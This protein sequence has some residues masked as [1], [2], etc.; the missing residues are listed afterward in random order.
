MGWVQLGM[1]GG[2]VGLAI[3]IIVHLMSGRRAR[4]IDLGTLRFLKVVLRENVRRKR[5]KRWLLLALRLTAVALLAFLFARP[6]LLARQTGGE[7]RLVI[8]LV[9][10]SASMGLGSGGQRPLDAAVRQATTVLARCGE[11]TQVEAAWFDHAIH[12]WAGLDS[13]KTSASPPGA[14]GS[15]LTEWASSRTPYGATDLGAAMAWA[16]DVAKQS[17]RSRKELYVYTDLQRSGLDRTAA[18]PLP[19]DLQV[20][21]VDL[22]RSY[23]ENVAVTAIELPKTVVRPGESMAI[24]VTLRNTGPFVRDEVPVT[25][26]LQNG[27]KSQEFHSQVRIEAGETIAVGFD[28][29]ALPEGLWQGTASIQLK[30]SLP[31]D[32]R[33]HLA[34]LVAPPI[35]VILVDGDAG[36]TGV[37]AETY[38]LEAAIGLAG[39]TKTFAA[40]LFTATRAALSGGAGLP[41]LRGVS[42]VVLANLP[43]LDAAAAQRL[44]DFVKRGAGLLVFS[45]ENVQADGYRSL[46]AAGIGVGQI[47]GIARAE[48]LPWR[49]EE[50][51]RAHPALEF[52]NDPQYGDLRRP[53]FQAYTRIQPDADAKVVAWFRGGEPAVL[54]KKLGAGRI[55]WVTT[56]CDFDW[57]D[58]PRSRLYVPMVHQMLGYLAHL[59]EGGPVRNVPLEKA[60]QGPRAVPG[61]FQCEGFHEVVNVDPRESESERCTAEQFAARFRFQVTPEEDGQTATRVAR[62]TNP[63]QLRQD[64]IWQWLVLGLFGCLLAEGF[65]GNRTTA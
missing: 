31:F 9:D 34:F 53:A 19:D 1:L 65:L 23:P 16:G 60:A 15:R 55:L 33:R 61:V 59:A 47:G 7:D 58:W 57:G 40:S 17:R 48:S 25:L 28:L 36:R 56:A 49:F 62:A 21:L 5:L 30:D 45:G 64:E 13:A 44:A 29:P 18:S 8:L 41:D 46:Q 4:R 43:E 39:P 54:E 42:L 63:N 26:R 24:G 35:H 14:L 11:G 3:P 2:L 37:T 51:D 20:R 38:F 32:D 6:Y 22:G 10:R 27:S 52:F 50:W 12:P